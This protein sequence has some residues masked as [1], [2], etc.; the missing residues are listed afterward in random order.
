MIY[1]FLAVGTLAIVV[2]LLLAGRKGQVAHKQDGYWEIPERESF[3]SIVLILNSTIE[4]ADKWSKTAAKAPSDGGEAMVAVWYRNSLAKIRAD[5][6]RYPWLLDEF[7]N[8]PNV[9]S[10]SA[11][12]RLAN[13]CES[14]LEVLRNVKGVVP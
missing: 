3:E 13:R 6:E 2:V 7:A 11:I 8:L 4:K 1:I 12:G 9:A 5:C 14:V 10:S